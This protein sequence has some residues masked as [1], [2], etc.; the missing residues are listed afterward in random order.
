LCRALGD[1]SHH[2]SSTSWYSKIIKILNKLKRKLKFEVLWWEIW[3]VSLFHFG[4]LRC[5][6]LHDLE[7]TTAIFYIRWASDDVC[8][9]DVFRLVFAWDQL[10]LNTFPLAAQ[11][12]RVT[13]LQISAV[14]LLKIIWFFA[15]ISLYS[16]LVEINISNRR[17]T[18]C[19]MNLQEFLRSIRK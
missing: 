3:V 15:L 2:Q 5:G 12:S 6:A 17:P 8:F 9:L 18:S 14:G 1:R 4:W 13:S 19:L 10:Q 7:V 16:D 11:V